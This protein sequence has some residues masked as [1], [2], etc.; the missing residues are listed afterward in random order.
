MASIQLRIGCGN[1]PPGNQQADASDGQ[2]DR[3]P[4]LDL[5]ARVDA[6][7]VAE[8]AVGNELDL[9]RDAN[10]GGVVGIQPSPDPQGDRIPDSRPYCLL[11]RDRIDD[12]GRRRHVDSLF[13]DAG[14]NTGAIAGRAPHGSVRTFPQH[15]GT[16]T[17]RKSLLQGVLH[18]GQGHDKG[19]SDGPD[20]AGQFIGLRLGP[21]RIVVRDDQRGP[22]QFLHVH[23]G[24]NRK[25]RSGDGGSLSLQ[26]PDSVVDPLEFAPV[27]EHVLRLDHHGDLHGVHGGTD[28]APEDGHHQVARPPSGFVEVHVGAGLVAH[29]RVGVLPHGAGQVG[30]EVQGGDDRNR[31]PQQV[32][33]LAQD[34]AV[35]TVDPL[36]GP[37]AVQRQEQPVQGSGLPDLLLEVVQQRSEVVSLDPAVTDGPPAQNGDNPR[38]RPGQGIDEAMKLAILRL[39]TF[40][41]L[42][43]RSHQE[44]AA[45]R[46]LRGKSIRLLQ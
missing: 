29:Q 35:A 7:L 43:T 23:P 13:Q 8:L 44:V 30:V 37:G 22:T 17:D 18:R 38:P 32:S 26:G 15:H 5:A 36:A 31:G 25:H 41:Q 20:E 21:G 10:R 1:R 3:P 33:G 2:H 46:E 11:D 40:D 34:G 45:D 28:L 39:V 6:A 19:L 24:L 14:Q 16:P 9:A 12:H 27:R 42:V 4:H